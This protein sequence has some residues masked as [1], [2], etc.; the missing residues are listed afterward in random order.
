MQFKLS[1]YTS[2]WA[3]LMHGQIQA[4]ICRQISERTIYIYLLVDIYNSK[5]IEHCKSKNQGL[6]FQIQVDI[7]KNVP[8]C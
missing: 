7:C 3:L 5:W 2:I 6:Q 1:I 4:L 8:H